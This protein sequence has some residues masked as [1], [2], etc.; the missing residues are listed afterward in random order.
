VKTGTKKTLGIV[1][2]VAG[3]AT[4]G[5][6]VAGQLG[7]WG[8][9]TES[10]TATTTDGDS[11]PSSS[12]STST[13]LPPAEDATQFLTALATALATGDT[14]F[15]VGRLNPA[16]VGRYGSPQCLA[17]L[18]GAQDPSAQFTVKAVTGPAEYDWTTDDKTVKVADTLTVEVDRVQRGVTQPATIHLA[19]VDGQLT[20]F[21]DC[22][23]PIGP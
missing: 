12:T 1:L 16:V 22:G 23:N 18:A 13:T 21:V 15:L 9:K 17:A 7:S 5:I 2:L 11:T 8:A 19:S 14:N 20:W 6:G 4:I 3:V 10:P